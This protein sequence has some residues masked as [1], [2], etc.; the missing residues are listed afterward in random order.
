MTYEVL[1]NNLGGE[2]QASCLLVTPPPNLPC[3]RGIRTVRKGKPSEGGPH[4]SGQP[5]SGHQ[6]LVLRSFS[7][8][9]TCSLHTGMVAGGEKEG[10]LPG[11][12]A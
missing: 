4:P 3:T 12:K 1:F 11:R 5:V 7:S 2:Y 8:H 6:Y 10:T 9:P